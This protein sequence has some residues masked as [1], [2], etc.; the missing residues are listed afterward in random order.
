LQAHRLFE[1][2]VVAADIGIKVTH[3]DIDVSSQEDLNNC[4][5]S[6]VKLIFGIFITVV[7]WD[8]ALYDVH[9]DPLLFCFEQ[10]CDDA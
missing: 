3:D 6:T 8:I 10:D 1:A 2:G 7:G 5:Q 9:V 4:L